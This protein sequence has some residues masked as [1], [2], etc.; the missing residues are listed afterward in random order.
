[1][2]DISNTEY[3]TINKDGVFVGGKPATVY[4][5]KAISFLDKIKANFAALRNENPELQE[6]H[7]GAFETKGVFA[8]KGN[9]S[10]VFGK[11]AWIRVKMS[12]GRLGNWA[13]C[14]TFGSASGCACYCANYCGSI[15]RINSDMRSAMFNFTKED[16][17]TNTENKQTEQS[18]KQSKG[19]H[20]I[21]SA[22]KIGD[23]KITIEKTKQR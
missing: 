20:K 5:R 22:I 9:P 23:F 19:Q 10:E 12:D 11:N 17:E 21:I 16:K 14:N 4:H 6:L 1:M 8:K 3:I 13:F 2:I 7:V 18:K 15:V